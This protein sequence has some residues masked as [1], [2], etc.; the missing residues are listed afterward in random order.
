MHA[1]DTQC[2]C[3]QAAEGSV[4][5]L[6]RSALCRVEVPAEETREAICSSRVEIPALVMEKSCLSWGLSRC[7]F[8]LGYRM[9]CRWVV[10]SPYSLMELNMYGAG[11]RRFADLAAVPGVGSTVGVGAGQVGSRGE[12]D[13]RIVTSFAELRKIVIQAIFSTDM[14]LFRQHHDAMKRRAQMKTSRCTGYEQTLSLS[15]QWTKEAARGVRGRSHRSTAAV[16]KSEAVLRHRTS[17]FPAKEVGSAV[18]S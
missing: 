15:I 13:D 12:V 3:H 14:E 7:V 2:T 6:L 11:E 17:V 5:S 8:V 4:L 18:F 1:A 16:G 10:L 9:L